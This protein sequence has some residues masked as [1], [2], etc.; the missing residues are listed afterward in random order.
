MQIWRCLSSLLFTCTVGSCNLTQGPSG[1]VPADRWHS[2]LLITYVLF[3]AGQEDCGKRAGNF[4]TATARTHCCKA[5]GESG[6]LRFCTLRQELADAGVHL[7]LSKSIEWSQLLSLCK[8]VASTSQI[9][10]LIAAKTPNT[11]FC[12]LGSREPYCVFE[13]L[14]SAVIQCS[15]GMWECAV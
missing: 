6:L 5:S 7:N 11:R 4:Q 14:G 15:T 2:F 13:E 3:D 12:S 9:T 10:S 1:F 8:V